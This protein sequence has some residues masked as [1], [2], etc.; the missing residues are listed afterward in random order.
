MFRALSPLSYDYLWREVL[1]KKKGGAESG[2][3]RCAPA[4]SCPCA[5]A[6][7]RLWGQAPPAL[8]VE[9]ELAPLQVCVQPP[10]PHQI[11]RWPYRRRFNLFL[12]SHL[13][14]TDNISFSP[15]L[16]WVPLLNVSSPSISVILH[17]RFCVRFKHETKPWC[18]VGTV[19]GGGWRSCQLFSANCCG[20]QAASP[21]TQACT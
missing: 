4:A 7:D 5:G 15:H 9:R 17:G 19:L 13:N 12:N 3:A 16:T 20:H 18:K 8:P 14:R 11:H 1:G 6:G 10:K 21:E 2:P